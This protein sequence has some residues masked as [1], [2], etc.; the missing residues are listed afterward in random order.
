M[1]GPP[2][3]AA[4]HQICRQGYTFVPLMLQLPNTPDYVDVIHDFLKSSADTKKDLCTISQ[5]GRAGAA[6]G[7]KI[8]P[9]FGDYRCC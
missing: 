3:L 7:K 5:G 8:K 4:A 1:L 6:E 9:Q 2:L